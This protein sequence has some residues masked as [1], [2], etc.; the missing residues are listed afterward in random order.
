MKKTIMIISAAAALVACGPKGDPQ[1]GKAS[2][3]KV[4]DAMTI[5][6]K[7]HL[8]IGTG[9]ANCYYFL[10]FNAI[11]LFFSQFPDFSFCFFVF[12]KFDYVFS[13]NFA[14]FNWKPFF[15]PIFIDSSY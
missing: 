3:D 4:I 5:E 13:F 1:L 7:A 2:L 14:F 9:M 15:F 11:I 12:K 10:C 6:E 8:L